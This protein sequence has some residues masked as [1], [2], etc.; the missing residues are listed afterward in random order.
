MDDQVAGTQT[1]N[2]M[3]EQIVLPFSKR[4]PGGVV[5]S[6]AGADRHADSHLPGTHDHVSS[7]IE[8]ENRDG[9]DNQKSYGNEKVASGIDPNVE[10]TYNPDNVVPYSPQ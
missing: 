9:P 8:D 5:D 4:H 6:L 2:P 7:V 3:P 10:E 1:N